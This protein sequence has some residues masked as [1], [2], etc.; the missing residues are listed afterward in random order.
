MPYAVYRLTAARPET[1]G[2]E[3]MSPMAMDALD[4]R[5]AVDA[6]F[7]SF[8]K[9]PHDV[10]KDL[11]AFLAKC[12]KELE[13]RR[14]PDDLELMYR[15]EM[16]PFAD[17]SGNLIVPGESIGMAQILMDAEHDA[18]THA[19]HDVKLEIV[20][21]LDATAEHLIDE[22]LQIVE[23]KNVTHA[24]ALASN[25]FALVK[26]LMGHVESVRRA[27]IR[28]VS[29]GVVASPE[30]SF[31]DLT[32]AIEIYNRLHASMRWVTL[33]KDNKETN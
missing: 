20:C 1:L 5:A 27:A 12:R 6:R 11:F 4:H 15:D 10:Q 17:T 3:A 14:V 18:L 7:Y 2:L 9:E 23:D 22:A 25:P 16:R 32:A 30:D 19:M 21:V 24:L 33:A 26:D 13:E 31:E 28:C 8:G 29:F